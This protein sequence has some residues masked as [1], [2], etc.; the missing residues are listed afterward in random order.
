MKDPGHCCACCGAHLIT[1]EIRKDDCCSVKFHILNSD[2]DNV[3]D[4]HI[5]SLP[6]IC[7][8]LFPEPLLLFIPQLASPRIK[9]FQAVFRLVAIA[10]Y[11]KNQQLLL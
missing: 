1:K 5:F 2:Q 7:S 3:Q 11:D 8:H 10:L 4:N 9:T 6:V